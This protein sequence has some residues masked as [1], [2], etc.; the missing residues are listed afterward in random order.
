LQ[1]LFQR[2]P[3]LNKKSLSLLLSFREKFLT[4]V[5]YQ[6]FFGR[7]LHCVQVGLCAGRDVACHVCTSQATPAAGFSLLSLSAYIYAHA[8]A[9]GMRRA[10]VLARMVRTAPKDSVA[11]STPTAQQERPN[12]TF[13]NN[14][15]MYHPKSGIE[16]SLFNNLT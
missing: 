1:N 16:R 4:D 3:H 15:L 10:C 7:V 2:L 5:L 6:K 9:L 14:V 8:Y 12:K 13:I 11:R